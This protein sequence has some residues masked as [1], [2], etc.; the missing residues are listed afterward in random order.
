MIRAAMLAALIAATAPAHAIPSVQQ[1]MLASTVMVGVQEPETAG[2]S[3]YKLPGQRPTWFRRFA[4][5]LAFGSDVAG[6]PFAGLY[7]EPGAGVLVERDRVLTAAHVVLNTQAFRKGGALFVRLQDGRRVPASVE[8]FAPH[9]DAAVLRI[10]L[11]AGEGPEPLPLAYS[12]YVEPGTPVLIAGNPGGR[13]WWLEKGRAVRL[14]LLGYYDEAHAPALDER[15]RYG[16]AI[17]GKAG[18]GSS[19]GPVVNDRGELVAIVSGALDSPSTFAA[20]PA[21]TALRNVQ[22]WQGYDRTR[23]RLHCVATRTKK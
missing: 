6:N 23:T 10:E 19:G 7:Y 22:F 14:G 18:N 20:V 8:A 12:S 2:P 1:R 13:A 16:W 4:H 15:Q 21:D 11:G 3:L 9:F 17:E 5:W